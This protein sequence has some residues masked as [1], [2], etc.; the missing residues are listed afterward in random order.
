[1]ASQI[2]IKRSSVA[3][4][5]PT[6]SDIATGELAINTK[7]KKIYSSNGTVVFDFIAPYLEVAN[8]TSTYLPKTNPVITGTLTANGSVGTAGYYLRTSGSGIYWSTAAGGAAG[9]AVDATSQ[10]FTGN[11]S[12]TNFTLSTSVVQQ[13]NVIV[14]INGILQIPTTHYT[15]SGA[16]LAFTSAPYNTAV[17]EARSME[18]VVVAG[19]TG[20]AGTNGTNGATGATGPAGPAGDPYIG[21]L[22]LGGM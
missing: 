22:L 19:L 21:W 12:Q 2:K 14:T 5:V 18:G 4:K 9:A 16:T 8:A 17:I 10:T 6:T 11:G 13:K 20:A 1:V 7:D 15:I 3:G